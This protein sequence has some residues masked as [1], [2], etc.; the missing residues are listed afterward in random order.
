MPN[1]PALPAALDVLAT[2]LS[3]GCRQWPDVTGATYDRVF[4]RSMGARCAANPVGQ[5]DVLAY[6]RSGD[7]VILGPEGTGRSAASP[8][9]LASGPILAEHGHWMLREAP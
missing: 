6:L 8:A 2:D 5:G 9:A 7:A 1:D 4:F 3:H